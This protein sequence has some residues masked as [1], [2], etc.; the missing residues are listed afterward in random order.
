MELQRKRALLSGSMNCLQ[1]AVVLRSD[2]KE[3]DGRLGT[4]RRKGHGK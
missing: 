1:N 2:L 4:I 3:Y